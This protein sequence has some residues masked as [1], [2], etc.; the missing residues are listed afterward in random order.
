MRR[1]ELTGLTFW[2]WTVE[3]FSNISEKG[4]TLWDCDCVCGNKGKV[5][6]YN[7]KSG[8]SKSCGCLAIERGKEANI[9]HGMAKTPLHKIWLGIKQRCYNANSA[10]YK[11]Y[12]GRGIKLSEEWLDFQKFYADM[13]WTYKTGLTIE[14]LDVNKNYCKENCAWISKIDQ[15]RNR[16]NTIWV[17][18]EKGIMTV[19]EAA[20]LAG[21]SW[22]C[23][24]NRHLRNCSI[25]KILLPANQAGR[26]F[27]NG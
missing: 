6:G 9:T 11:N 10:S 20:K 7:L 25:D 14:R 23:M 19:T 8:H 1:L 5:S 15:S 26:S 16:T 12:G 22:F 3:K 24:Y 21:V 17:T 18:T 4:F 2:Y 27:T 13:I